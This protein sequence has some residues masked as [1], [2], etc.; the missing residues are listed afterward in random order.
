M[1]IIHKLTVSLLILL[2]T[3]ISPIAASAASFEFTVTAKTAFDKM[4]AA[5]NQATASKLTTQYAEL[6]AV[7]KKAIEWDT[8]IDEL[9]YRNEEAILGTRQRI[10]EIDAAKLSRLESDVVQAKKKYEPL[11]D[12]YDSLRQQLSLAKSY[13]NKWLVSVL[14]PQVET[15]KAAVQLAKLDIRG[16]EAALKTAKAAAAKA[17][18]KL[19]DQLTGI[20]KIKIKI[21]AA[22]SSISSTN[23]HFRTETSILN[24]VV[25][26]GNSTAAL[27]S[28]ARLLS[29]MKQINEQKQK[30]YAYE[31]QIMDVIA[32]VDAQLGMK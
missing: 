27:S 6:Q 29:F 23:K 21:K 7:Q 10:K 18:K 25:R 4:K 17:M 16:K 13:K 19:R 28:F 26:K 31:Q 15:A 1:R 5:A 30:M 11:F 32:K 8:K 22:K 9:H 20:D 3:L 24:Q 12:L 14:N 2:L